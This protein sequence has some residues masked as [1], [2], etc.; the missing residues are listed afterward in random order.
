MHPNDASFI[1]LLQHSGRM[2]LNPIGHWPP[3]S[4][5]LQKYQKNPRKCSEGYFFKNFKNSYFFFPPFALAI[6]SVNSVLIA[7]AFSTAGLTFSERVK[8]SSLLVKPA[9]TSVNTVS[10]TPIS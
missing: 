6:T 3:L 4:D 10:T 2:S 7:F 9:E 8:I 5:C 1:Q